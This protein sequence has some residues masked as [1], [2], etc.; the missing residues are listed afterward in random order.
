MTRL[1]E[2]VTCEFTES[3]IPQLVATETAYKEKG[4]KMLVGYA[5]VR[6]HIQTCIGCTKQYNR[7]RKAS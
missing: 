3:Q 2:T 4:G 5:A 6:A 1:A 7:A